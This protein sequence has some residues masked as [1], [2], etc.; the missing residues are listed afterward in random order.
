MS[1][2]GNQTD[3]VPASD[4]ITIPVYSDKVVA[5]LGGSGRV[6]TRLRIALEGKVRAVRV[7]DLKSPDSLQA[8]ETWSSVDI[9]D[10]NSTLSA[11]NGVDAIIHLA[12]FPGERPIE[13]IVR[14]NVLG[15]HNVYEAARELGIKRVVLGSSN[16]V[17]GFFARDQRVSP[18]GAMRPD[19]FYGLSKCWNE[20]EAGLYFQKCGIESFIIRIANASMEP[21]DS[22][23][24]ERSRATWVSPRDL[25]QLVLIGLESLE[26]DCTTVYGV[27]QSPYAWWDNSVAEALGYKPADRGMDYAIPHPSVPAAG[28]KQHISAHFQGGRFCAIGHDGVLRVLRTDT[29]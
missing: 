11:L 26:V 22:R 3:A 8:N 24:D 12:G 13:D 25:A 18:V 28:E 1:A 29:N 7:L 6:G 10:L 9:C 21:A 19:S 20:L 23:S 27:S 5:V 16:H 4:D 15:T 17:T 2:E 14:V